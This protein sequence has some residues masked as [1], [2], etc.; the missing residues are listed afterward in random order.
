MLVVVGPGALLQARGN[1]GLSLLATGL[2]A[3]LIQPL[4]SRL[5]RAVNHLLYGE[6]DEHYKVISRLGQRLEATL[7]PEA[8]LPTI[9]ETVTGALKL[10]YAAISLKQASPFTPCA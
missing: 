2:I 6:R 5:Q 9:V 1:L 7:A 10:P 8:V 4:H 3:V